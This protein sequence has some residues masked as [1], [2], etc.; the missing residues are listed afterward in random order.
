ME[1]MIPDFNN[2]LS[3]VVFFTKGNDREKENNKKRKKKRKKKR[4]ISRNISVCR[5]VI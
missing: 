2:A 1:Q 5:I 3:C 4:N